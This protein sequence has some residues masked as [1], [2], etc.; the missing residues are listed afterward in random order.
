V[1]KYI[2]TV[3]RVNNFASH[4]GFGL[5]ARFRIA[6]GYTRFTLDPCF[7]MRSRSARS[8]FSRRCQRLGAAGVLSFASPFT[9]GS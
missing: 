8:R 2:T 9:V 1:S 3:K 5:E 6:A 4:A 7:L